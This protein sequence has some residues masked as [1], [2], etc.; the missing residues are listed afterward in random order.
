[1]ATLHR[2]DRLVAINKIMALTQTCATCKFYNPQGCAVAPVYWQAYQALKSVG[3]EARKTLL[4]IL[5]DCQE[6]QKEADRTVSITMPE[7]KWRELAEMP[8]QSNPKLKPLI[9]AARAELNMDV[10]DIQ[11]DDIPF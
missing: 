5:I 11:Y 4:P 3:L 9:Q 6:W 2:E 8:I 10:N 1:M 7:R